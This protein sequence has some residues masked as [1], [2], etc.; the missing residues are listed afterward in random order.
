[1]CSRCVTIFVKEWLSGEALWPK[2][3]VVGV[4]VM[5]WGDGQ[6]FYPPKSAI[7][8]TCIRVAAALSRARVRARLAHPT[9]S[10]KFF[11]IIFFFVILFLLLTI[12]VTIKVTILEICNRATY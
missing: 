11:F 3:L 9:P 8:V 1:M 7:C 10:L 2:K 4:Q 12:K 5:G 6:F